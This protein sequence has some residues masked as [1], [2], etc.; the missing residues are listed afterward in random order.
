MINIPSTAI[1]FDH[2]EPN[3]AVQV[4]KNKEALEEIMN[5]L[6]IDH[7][8]VVSPGYSL[9]GNVYRNLQDEVI[10]QAQIIS[11]IGMDIQVYVVP[12]LRRIAELEQQIRDLQQYISELENVIRELNSLIDMLN[13]KIAILIENSG[14]ELLTNSDVYLMNIGYLEILLGNTLFDDNMS[15]YIAE[16]IKINGGDLND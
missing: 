13:R 3:L 12:L 15:D 2:I 7:D 8:P 10:H 6:G 11:D 9:D 4:E 5:T 14:N 1:G 16:L